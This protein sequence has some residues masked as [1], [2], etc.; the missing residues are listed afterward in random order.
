M[1]TI[2]EISNKKVWQDFIEKKYVGF[3][4]FFQSWNWGEVQKKVNTTIERLGIYENEKLIGIVSATFISAKR[5]KYVHLRHGP[6][7]I[8]YK[9]EYIDFLLSYL[10]ERAKKTG[11]SFIRLSPLIPSEK[12]SEIFSKKKFRDAQ[13]HRMDA[14]VCWILPLDISEEEILKNM[15]KS[16]RYLIKKSLSSGVRIERTQNLNKIKL[17]LPLYKKLAHKKHFVAHGGVS[18]EFEVFVKNNQAEL[19]LAYFENK[20]ISGALIDFVDGMAIYR[21]SASDD[22]YRHIP[23]MYLLQWEVI[24]EAK[25]RKMKAYNFWGIAPDDN[26]RHPWKGVSLFK[27]GF[28][29]EKREFMHGKDYVLSWKYWLIYALERI[30]KLRKGY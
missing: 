2:K 17:F 16:H 12:G 29:G 22:L 5:G 26:P 19:F 15:R 20:V 3:S 7:F 1:L 30:T 9:K 24:K 8:E 14:E 11:F 13:I 18:E 28:G 23:A 27:T 21:H 25:R 10:E 4:P 6:L